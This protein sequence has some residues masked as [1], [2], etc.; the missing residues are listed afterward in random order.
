MLIGVVGKTNT[1]KSTF[2]KA[3]TLAEVEI[4]NRPFVTIKP[5]HGSGYV[6]IGCADK[7]FNVKC[8]P[9]LGY[10]INSNRF[11]PIDLIDVAGL[12]P[13]A[14]LGKGMGNQF[15]DDL[16]EADALIHIVDISGS[17]DAEGNFVKPLSYDPSN[18][19]QF[20]ED[21]LDYWYLRILKKGWEKFVRTIKQENKDVKKAIAKQL[22]GLRV[23]EELAEE[24]IKNLNLQHN[25]E[26]WS[27]EDLLNLARELRKKTKPIIIAAN[28][29]DIQGAKFNLEKLKEKFPDYTILPCSAESELALREAA[30][31]NLIKYIPGEDK[32]EVLDKNLSE[33]QK[34]GLEFLK[35]F[36]KENKTTG[37]QEVL[38]KIVFHVLK[39]MAVYPVANPHLKD[40]D[41]NILPDCFLLKEESTALDLAETIHTDFA[42]NFVKAIDVRTKRII[43]KEHKLKNL[44]IVEIMLK[45]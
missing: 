36:L 9:R 2:F 43:G 1:G 18:D 21:E 22:S 8:N 23:T 24:I 26:E 6:K 39:Y 7:E 35:N 13:G 33:Q 11:I 31:N 5:N 41:G 38:N 40:K 12:V 45:K 16:N 44:D 25:P 30:K 29:I 10:C 32:F 14:H 4:S 27:E 42:K 37:I 20:L 28:K 34:K 17:T 19:V 15:L 3:A